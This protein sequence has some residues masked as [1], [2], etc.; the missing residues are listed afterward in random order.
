MHPIKAAMWLVS[1]D[2]AAQVL[3]FTTCGCLQEPVQEP[4]AHHAAEHPCA[5]FE[6]VLAQAE[7]QNLLALL[8]MYGF[9]PNGARSYYTNRRHVKHGCHSCCQD[10][11][12]YTVH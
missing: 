1:L 8:R 12:L 3:L 2:M 9:V 7:V 4:C 6:E 10:N 5:C 11:L